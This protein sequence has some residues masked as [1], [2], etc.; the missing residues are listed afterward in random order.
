MLL[1]NLKVTYLFSYVTYIQQQRM[2]QTEKPTIL[3][4]RIKTTLTKIIFEL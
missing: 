2:M 4:E 1:L 3:K